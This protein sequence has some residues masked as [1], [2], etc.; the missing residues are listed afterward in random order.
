M[1]ALIFE[2]IRSLDELVQ[3]YAGLLTISDNMELLI[4]S[5]TFNKVPVSW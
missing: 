5:I 2:I 4:N 3:G 1:N